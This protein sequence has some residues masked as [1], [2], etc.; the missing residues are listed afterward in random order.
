MRRTWEGE[1]TKGYKNAME[2]ATDVN[3]AF[4]FCLGGPEE[5]EN[6]LNRA[7]WTGAR[8]GIFAQADPKREEN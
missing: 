2:G 3:K 1:Y 4:R 8:D 7:Y 6:E 5:S